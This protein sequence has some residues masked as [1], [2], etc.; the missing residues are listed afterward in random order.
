MIG[1]FKIAPRLGVGEALSFWL[2]RIAMPIALSGLAAIV[3]GRFGDARGVLGLRSAPA[4]VLAIAL[5]AGL[6]ALAAVSWHGATQS[7]APLLGGEAAKL[8]LR[9]AVQQAWFEEVLARGLL[10]GGLLALGRSARR[11]LWVSSLAF[12]FSHV[13]QF[14]VPPITVEGLLNGLA[15]VVLTLPLGLALGALTLR[16][17]SIGPAVVLHFLVDLTILPQKLLVPSL[18]VILVATALAPAVVFVWW[19]RAPAPRR[20]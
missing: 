11:A 4:S 8:A 5:V 12:A 13:L 20:S 18:P 19:R 7:F 15:Y 10:L 14:L 9:V 2:F 16:S 1:L 17:R 6:P 3:A